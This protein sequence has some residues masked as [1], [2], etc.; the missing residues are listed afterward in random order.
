MTRSKI[1]GKFARMRTIAYE[2]C[3]RHLS[4]RTASVAGW[5]VGSRSNLYWEIK[6]EL[7]NVTSA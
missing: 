5:Y 4:H 2:K 3:G 1:P 7:R 6:E